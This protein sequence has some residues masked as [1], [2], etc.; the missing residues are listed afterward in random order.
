MEQSGPL[1]PVS[2]APGKGPAG[3]QMRADA[4][5]AE[6][7]ETSLPCHVVRVHR[8]AVPGQK[9]GR[10]NVRATHAPNYP[11]VLQ[12]AMITLEDRPASNDPTKGSG[13]HIVITGSRGDSRTS[14]HIIGSEVDLVIVEKP[15]LF[16]NRAGI[17]GSTT[18]ATH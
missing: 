16:P 11:T 3:E 18:V 5:G 14:C 2:P 7:I 4:P 17:F 6:W 10:G 9:D 1:V 8:A 15:K 12:A 13:P